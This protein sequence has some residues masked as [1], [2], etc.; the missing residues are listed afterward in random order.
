VRVRVPV[1]RRAHV[2]DH[3]R[4]DVHVHVHI[5]MNNGHQT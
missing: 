2:R 4:V 3:V 5:E 1:C